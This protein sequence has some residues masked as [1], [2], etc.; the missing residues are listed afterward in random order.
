M[1]DQYR[2]ALQRQGFEVIVA[3]SMLEAR[4][5]APTLQPTLII[6]DVDF[7]G[8]EGWELL[9]ELHMREDTADIPVIIATLSEERER[10]EAQGVFAFLQRPYAPDQ[11]LEAVTRAEQAA[12]IPRILL[13]DDQDDALR[14]LGDLLRDHGN[15]RVYTA[16]SGM[17]GLMQ[18]A[19]RRPQLVILD[20]RMPEMD[21][22]A[23]L[24]ELRQNPETSHI[25][26]MIVT[27]D[28]TLKE[29]E[30]QQLMQVHVVQKAA[31]S[32]NE[33]DGFI[34]GVSD[35]LRAN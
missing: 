19:F 14:L 30:R 20:L 18:V 23:V 29:D 17:E 1:V 15:F 31:I 3:S 8:G 22:F 10:A 4:A 25:P 7:N 33:Y 35:N 26:V 27:N 11:L 2:R 5:V 34:K 21:G 28:D 32:L 16:N 12:N 13:I 6:M 9:E 24:Q